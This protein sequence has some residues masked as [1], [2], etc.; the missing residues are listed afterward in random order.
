MDQ[1]TLRPP[2]SPWHP[3]LVGE[4]HWD[5]MYGKML[6]Y[7]V[8]WN[9]YRMGILILLNIIY[10]YIHNGIY[11]ENINLVIIGLLSMIIS[12]AN[13]HTV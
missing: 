10:I 13:V 8:G 9:G 6:G 7:H 11:L 4:R 3:R 2:R 5:W 12:I 1:I